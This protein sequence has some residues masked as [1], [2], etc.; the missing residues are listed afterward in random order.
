M[1]AKVCSYS[2]T[3]IICVRTANTIINMIDNSLIFTFD[4]TAL[5]IKINCRSVTKLK[6]SI[7]NFNTAVNGMV[8]NKQFKNISTGINNDKKRAKQRQP[9]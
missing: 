9:K 3:G 2:K 8:K 6:I 1:F 5:N 4:K 7:G